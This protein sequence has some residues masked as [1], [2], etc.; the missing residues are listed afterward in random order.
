MS[1]KAKFC[2][3]ST[4]SGTAYLSLF[5]SPSSIFDDLCDIFIVPENS[6]LPTL[7]FAWSS[8]HECLYIFTPQSDMYSS[9]SPLFS[10]MNSSHPF[11]LEL[12]IVDLADIF[13]IQ[14]I[15]EETIKWKECWY[16]VTFSLED[17]VYGSINFP[18]SK[19]YV[20][21]SWIIKSEKPNWHLGFY[22]VTF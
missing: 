17:Y 7:R 16:D 14:R 5:H 11:I 4:K 13:E 1:I 12:D 10:I 18:D 6:A 22:Y 19:Y 20:K 2:S 8:R 9:L 15:V 3:I 21:F